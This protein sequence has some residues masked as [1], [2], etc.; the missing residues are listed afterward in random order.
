LYAAGKNAQETIFVGPVQDSRSPFGRRLI[1]AY[2]VGSNMADQLGE[3]TPEGWDGAVF[4]FD[5]IEALPG[6]VGVT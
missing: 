4:A 6:V 2:G 1:P 5:I 3:L